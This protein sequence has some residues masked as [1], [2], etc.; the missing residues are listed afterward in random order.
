MVSFLTGLSLY[1]R[2]SNVYF[3]VMNKLYESIKIRYFKKE[4]GEI[5]NYGRIIKILLFCFGFFLLYLIFYG[6]LQIGQN[7]CKKNYSIFYNSVPKC[8]SRTT[9]DLMKYL[10]IKNNF[11]YYQS[12][13]FY[14][15]S[16]QM[17]EKLMIVEK[18]TK[19]AEQSKSIYDQHT[20]FMDFKKYVYIRS[21]SF[22]QSNTCKNF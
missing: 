19:L 20:F 16:I 22:S 4:K 10:A 13:N 12:D 21:I 17:S 3:K 8:G 6:Y 14:N 2:R 1:R 7:M 11:I 15:Y 18:I 9:S 5:Y